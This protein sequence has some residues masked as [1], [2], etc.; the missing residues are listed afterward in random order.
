M[1]GFFINEKYTMPMII[2]QLNST[3]Y[4]RDFGMVY[5]VIARSIIPTQIAFVFFARYLVSGIT[6]GGVKK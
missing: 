6:I 4:L 5:L 3:E 2:S 1:K